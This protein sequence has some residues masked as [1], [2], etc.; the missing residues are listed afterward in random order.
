[1]EANHRLNFSRFALDN[2]NHLCIV[3]QTG[4]L[5]ASPLKLLHALREL[6]INADKKDD[7]LLE[8]FKSLTPAPD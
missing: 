3:F 1:M 4:A 8:E 7:L 5:D 6:A 2:D